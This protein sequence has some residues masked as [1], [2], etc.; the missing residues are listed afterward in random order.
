[1]QNMTVTII[2]DRGGHSRP[3]TKTVQKWV[4][5]IFPGGTT[6]KRENI[7]IWTEHTTGRSLCASPIFS[8]TLPLSFE[9]PISPSLLLFH[10]HL[11]SP[12]FRILT[13]LFPYF[14]SPFL[15]PFPLLSLFLSIIL[16]RMALKGVSTYGFALQ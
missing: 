10:F 2:D 12:P 1:M 13:V 4:L 3:I 14:S 6:L 11:P 16:P 5:A 9:F 7:E 15:H 8:P